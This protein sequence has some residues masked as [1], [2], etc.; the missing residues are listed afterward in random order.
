MTEGIYIAADLCNPANRL[1]LSDLS[2]SLS[3]LSFI[4]RGMGRRNLS[5]D[6]VT[7]RWHTSKLLT[8]PGLCIFIHDP[9]PPPHTH[10]HTKDRAKI[11]KSSGSPTQREISTITVWNPLLHYVSTY[12]PPPP[13][14]PVWCS[15]GSDFYN[16]LWTVSEEDMAPRGGKFGQ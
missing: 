6:C 16:L 4:I 5:N 3:L 8:T 11:W 1:K 15:V 9:P 7:K 2:L 12:H 10:T 13:V 14:K